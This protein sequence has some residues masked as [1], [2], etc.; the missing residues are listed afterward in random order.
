MT[1]TLNSDVWTLQKPAAVLAFALL[2][3]ICGLASAR[4]AEPLSGAVE[5]AAFVG[6]NAPMATGQ[7]VMT[8]RGPAVITGSLGSMN[9]TTLPGSGGVGLLMN[10][11]NGT[12]T[13]IVPGGLPQVVATPR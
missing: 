9:T 8:G 1:K 5:Q 12:S 6:S 4:A 2:G 7:S 3:G 11:D 13:L 10:N